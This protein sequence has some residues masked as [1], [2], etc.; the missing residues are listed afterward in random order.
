MVRE[1]A[2]LEAQHR[3]RWLILVVTSLAQLMAVLDLTIVNVALPSAQHDLG[4][5]TDTRQWIIT[6]Y[7]LALGSLLLLGG[8]LGDWFGRKWTFIAGVSGFA[9]ASGV[10]GAAGSFGMLVAARA[11]QGVF[12]A[13]LAPSA[14]ALVA[15]TFTDPAERGKAFGVFGA[16]AGGGAALGLLLGGVLTQ[17]IS[18]RACLYVNLVIAI[19]VALAALRLLVNRRPAERPPLDLAGTAA[20]SL[21]L[22]GLVY[23]FSNAE[24]H[25]WSAAVTIVMLA[26]SAL[27]LATF[28]AIESRTKHPLL[29]LRVVTDRA[30]GGSY[31]ALAIASAAIF[32]VFLFLTFFLQRTMGYSPSKTGLAFLPLTTAI[33]ASSTSSNVKLMP[34]LGPRP[35]I[36]VGMLLGAGAMA[37]LAQLTPTS[38]YGA[39]ILPALIILGLG[40]GATVAPAFNTATNDVN[41]TD[42]GVASAMANTSQQVGGAI[43]AA[44]LSTIFAS[45]VTSYLH[46]HTPS[47]TALA[48]APVHG[49]TVAFW[50]GA[51]AF[52]AGAL[53]VAALLPALRGPTTRT[54][55]SSAEPTAAHV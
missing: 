4:F 24:L 5:S 1:D 27:L 53:L 15:V 2:E 31:L 26:A 10:G 37:W 47:R 36:A 30:R 11:A 50:A 46:A 35:I 40:F 48:A 38:S 42:A 33:V 44:V 51:G 25:S 39:D 22:F 43:G 3:R 18:W 21:G 32:G 16:I 20:V 12:G 17:G 23:G 34:R 54:A 8:R 49:Y 6:A 41:P 14:L 19:P 29:P 13:I 45:A 52:A 7:A 55:E 9:L 28:V